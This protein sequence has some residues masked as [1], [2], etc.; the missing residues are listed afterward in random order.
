M[1][2]AAHA[3]HDFT[4]ALHLGEDAAGLLLQQNGTELVHFGEQID[5]LGGDGHGVP[6][7]RALKARM[8]AECKSRVDHLLHLIQI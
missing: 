5:I 2:E 1:T 4:G 3:V 8:L 6:P 7:W